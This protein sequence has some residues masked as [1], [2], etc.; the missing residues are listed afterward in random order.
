MKIAAIGD[1]HTKIN[2]PGHLEE[3]F[4]KISS[5]AGVLVLCGDLTDSGSPQEAEILAKELFNCTIP[6]VGVLGN[7]D[8]ALSKEDQV[9]KILHD[10]GRIQI[11]GEDPLVIQGVGF[12]GT[13]GFGGGFDSHLVGPFGE[14]IV[15]DFVY[16]S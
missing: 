7:H 16:E 5:E 10:S 9:K 13:K 12:A 3:L 2:S 11:L 6:V 1:L 8:F 4:Q 14:K 15:H